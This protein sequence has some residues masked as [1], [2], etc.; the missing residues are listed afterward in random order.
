GDFDRA[1]RQYQDYIDLTPAIAESD[2]TEV[3]RAIQDLLRRKEELLPELVISS[4]PRGADIYLDNRA[5]IR[6]QTPGKF[7]VEPGP[8]QLFLEKKGYEPLEKSFV[9]PTGKPLILE[10]E[11]KPVEEYGNVQ[12][13]ANVSGA[14]VFIDGK[15]VGITP[16]SEMPQLKIGFHQVILEKEGY[17][18]WE[19]RVE[20]N[21]GRTTLVTADLVLIEPPSSAPAVLGW[22]SLVLGGLCIG[23]AVVANHFAEQEFNDTEDF[24]TLHN[25]ELTGYVSG[26]VLLTLAT[27]LIVYDLVRDDPTERQRQGEYAARGTAGKQA[28]TTIPRLSFALDPGWQALLLGA[29]FSF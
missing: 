28:A 21:K 4:N 3:E 29:G 27:T 19:K 2:K 12:I 10:F 13:V 25:L 8:H 9:M 24:K 16:Y 26:G 11:L 15:N 20:V 5:K 6:G 23:G 17:L 7:R 14:R 22:T 1:I 18:R